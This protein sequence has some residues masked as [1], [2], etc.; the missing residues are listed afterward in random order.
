M[1]RVIIES[2]YAGDVDEHMRYLQRCIR[3]SLARGE[4]PYAS[5][6]ML[7][8]ALDDATP[9][10]R[11]AGI[12]AGFAWRSE[13]DATVVYTDYGISAGM[14]EGVRHAEATIGRSIVLYGTKEHAIEY[15]MI[16]RNEE[17]SR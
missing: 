15:R 17:P 16:G 3:D 1:R 4:S 2:P 11:K 9:E 12:E 5:H 7:T 10:E 13:A 6:Q 8:Q 14:A